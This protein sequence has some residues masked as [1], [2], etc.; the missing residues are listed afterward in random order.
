MKLVSTFLLAI[1]RKENTIVQ[2]QLFNSQPILLYPLL[3]HCVL[4]PVI[5]FLLSHCV[6]LVDRNECE[7]VRCAYRCVNTGGS[8]RCICPRGYNSSNYYC[9]GEGLVL[10]YCTSGLESSWSRDSLVGST[11]HQITVVRIQKF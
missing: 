7:S 6:V 10:K 8:Y 1:G 5:F 9:S 3:T 2:K 11:G 4:N